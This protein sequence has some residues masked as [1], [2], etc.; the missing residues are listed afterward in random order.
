MAGTE[1]FQGVKQPRRGVNIPLSSSA[2]FANGLE[3]YPFLPSV[4]ASVDL[5]FPKK[6]YSGNVSD[7]EG[8]LDLAVQFPYSFLWV[9]LQRWAG[10]RQSV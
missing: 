4:S 3:L 9:A 2:I 8:H 5:R 6:T 10:K 1:F 7:Q